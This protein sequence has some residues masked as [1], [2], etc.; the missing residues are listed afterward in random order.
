MNVSR[1]LLISHLRHALQCI[2]MDFF[3]WMVL[4]VSRRELTSKVVE[5]SGWRRSSATARLFA[6]KSR[7]SAKL[8]S[9]SVSVS[10]ACVSLSL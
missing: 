2:P 4:C 9:V 7:W 6:G 8:L 1:T 10:C 5:E 3:R